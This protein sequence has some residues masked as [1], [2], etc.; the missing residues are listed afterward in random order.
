MIA[1][2]LNYLGWIN[3]IKELKTPFRKVFE[4]IGVEILNYTEAMKNDVFTLCYITDKMILTATTFPQDGCTSINVTSTDEDKLYDFL[5]VLPDYFDILINDADNGIYPSQKTSFM[6]ESE[7]A[8]QNE[9]ETVK[10]KH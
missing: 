2:I 5:S 10:V 3:K 6:Q 8:E 7:E 1:K 4:D 9:Q